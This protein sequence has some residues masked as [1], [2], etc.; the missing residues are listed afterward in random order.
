MPAD[1][2]VVRAWVMFDEQNRAFHWRPFWDR[3]EGAARR[4]GGVHGRIGAAKS[5]AVV[6]ELVVAGAEPAGETPQPVEVEVEDDKDITAAQLVETRGE[7]RAI[8]RGAGG[9][10]R[11]E[12]AGATSFGGGA[13][14]VHEMYPRKTVTPV[15]CRKEISSGLSRRQ[16]GE[17]GAAGLFAGGSRQTVFVG[18]GSHVPIPA[19]GSSATPA[20]SICVAA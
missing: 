14:E 3:Q 2:V 4:L 16:S 11:V 18:N 20:D 8:G 12:C 5:D 10:E 7:V 19:G 15:L 6:A 9:A 1:D 17:S 13:D